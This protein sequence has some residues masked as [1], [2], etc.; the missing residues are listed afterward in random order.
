M[1]DKEV[2]KKLKKSMKTV[3]YCPGE[4]PILDFI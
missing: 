3:R 4:S 1:A 2:L